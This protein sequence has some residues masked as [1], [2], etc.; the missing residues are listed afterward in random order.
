MATRWLVGLCWAL[1]KLTTLHGQTWDWVQSG[2]SIESDFLDDAVTDR[3]GNTILVGAYWKDMNFNGYPLSYQ[4]ADGGDDAFIV[5]Y[6]SSGNFQWAQ[7]IKG[8]DNQEI[9]SV[10]TDDNGNVYLVGEYDEE[11]KL[12]SRTLT[13]SSEYRDNF[14]IAKYSSSGQYQWAKRLRTED[15]LR[16]ENIVTTASGDSYVSGEFKGRVILDGSSE[17]LYARSDNEHDAFLIKYSSSG[18]IIWQREIGGRGDDFIGQMILNDNDEL[19]VSGGFSDRIGGLFPSMTAV[20]STRNGFVAKLNPFGSAIWAKQT[21]D[22]DSNGSSFRFIA[23]D[24]TSGSLWLQG[25]TR[26]KWTIGSDTLE[27][28]HPDSNQSV[29]FTLKLSPLGT[30]EWT[31]VDTLNV[32]VYDLAVDENGFIY[33]AG[34][35][36]D[37]LHILGNTLISTGDNDAIAVAFDQNGSPVWYHTAVG[38][39]WERVENISASEPG[40]LYVAGVFY[41]TCYFDNEVVYG[42]KSDVYAARMSIPS[43]T[44]TNLNKQKSELSLSVFPNPAASLAFVMLPAKR[45]ASA[46]ISL[47]DVQRREVY[48]R[49]V[50]ASEEQNGKV[51][52]ELTSMPS[53]IYQVLLKDQG[54][55]LAHTKLSV[56]H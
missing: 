48:H 8:F 19:F 24:K 37:T 7:G 36:A 10:S 40:K 3:F 17:D 54:K 39:F 16:V 13:T 35:Y 22:P 31:H 12:G 25:H 15:D 2:G 14:F 30:L 56:L 28:W 23:T 11:A 1:L 46:S 4:D 51:L 50:S 18:S 32:N 49:S 26:G 9:V 27:A 55:V 21:F 29:R 6:D 20:G 43:S 5:K 34:N 42:G 52:I 44:S 47:Y 45:F 53:S 41:S 38:P 33:V